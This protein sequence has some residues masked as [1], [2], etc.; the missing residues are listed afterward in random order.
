MSLTRIPLKFIIWTC[1]VPL[2]SLRYDYTI[3]TP[4]LAYTLNFV[5][6]VSQQVNRRRRRPCIPSNV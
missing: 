5:H 6:F 3:E 2:T 4:N 1:K